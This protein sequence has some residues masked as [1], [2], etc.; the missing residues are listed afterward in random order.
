MD[1]ISATP[2]AAGRPCY[3]APPISYL[4][5]EIFIEIFHFFTLSPD[6][7]YKDQPLANATLLSS[8]CRRWRHLAIQTSSLWSTIEIRKRCARFQG[9]AGDGVFSEAEKLLG[10]EQLYLQRSRDCGLKVIF[11]HLRDPPMESFEAVADV[12][13]SAFSQWEMLRI[14]GWNCEEHQMH[15]VLS[16]FLDCCYRNPSQRPRLRSLSL[17]R[18]D[19]DAA[20]LEKMLL[21]VLDAAPIRSLELGSINLILPAN[22]AHSLTH[23][24]LESC[25]GDSHIT[26]MDLDTVLRR[27]A[28]LQSLRL[29]LVGTL[30][31]SQPASTPENIILPHLEEMRL[32]QAVPNPIQRF[33][34]QN[35]VAP[36]LLGFAILV[37]DM[38]FMSED[39]EMFQMSEYDAMASFLSS[40]PSIRSF[41]YAHLPEDYLTNALQ[42]LPQLVVLTFGFSELERFSMGAAEYVRPPVDI[43]PQLSE[44]R[45][46]ACREKAIEFSDLAALKYFIEARAALPDVVPL[47]ALTV[48]CGME[49]WQQAH[50]EELLELKE[51][52]SSRVELVWKHIERVAARAYGCWVQRNLGWQCLKDLKQLQWGR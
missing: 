13:L 46:D 30:D 52:L 38:D 42:A 45:I 5:D 28:Q 50:G 47:R 3:P 37:A 9:I 7:I 4:P 22:I 14:D 31:S 39:A 8:I 41:A 18:S 23:L 49:D 29:K 32:V 16:G 17:L 19:Q 34:Y 20:V 1:H 26:P 6:G 24:S 40:T 48:K 44:F 33:I 10:L 12:V 43:C 27:C 36:S 21:A 51:W 35:V 2:S 11:R 15:R 25:S